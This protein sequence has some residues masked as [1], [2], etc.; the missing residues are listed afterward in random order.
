MRKYLKHISDN[1]KPFKTYCRERRSRGGNFFR[2]KNY[3]RKKKRL[4]IRCFW[5]WVLLIFERKRFAHS[6]VLCA[7]DFSLKE[8]IVFPSAVL[9]KVQSLS[10]RGWISQ[11]TEEPTNLSTIVLLDQE[12]PIKTQSQKTHTKHALI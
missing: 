2:L 8:M 11:P 12:I 9:S 1:S 10:M 3:A 5:V 7:N 6:T 4:N